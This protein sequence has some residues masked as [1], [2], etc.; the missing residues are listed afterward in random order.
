M[1]YGGLMEDAVKIRRHRYQPQRRKRHSIPCPRL[2]EQFSIL[3]DGRVSICSADPSGISIIGDLN[4]K[5]IYEIWTGER[6][7]LVL[8]THKKKQA[9]EMS[10]CDKCDYTENCSVPAGEYF[11]E[12]NEN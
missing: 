3:V 4:R 1:N 12:F 2:F 7:K 11:G 10:P 8:E 9:S 5:S 6:R